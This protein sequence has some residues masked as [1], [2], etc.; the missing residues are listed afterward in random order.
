MSKSKISFSCNFK[1]SE[2][3]SL[4]L[5]VEVRKPNLAL[6]AQALTTQSVDLEPGTYYVTAKL[7][8]GQQLF[9]QVTVFEGKPETVP[10]NPDPEDESPHEWLEKD[11]Y[12]TGQK[13]T[14]PSGAS[15][16]PL[17]GLGTQDVTAKLRAFSGN[18]LLGG[19]QSRDDMGWLVPLPAPSP[20][21][22]K[23]NVF[24]GDV[25]F[26]QL[27]QPKVPALN[28]ALPISMSPPNGCQLVLTRQ[29]NGL[30]SVEAHVEH[31]AADT[32][33]RYFQRGFLE[34]A[35]AMSTSDI[36]QAEQL[37]YQ[38]LSYP[39]AATVGAYALLRFGDLSRLNN[40]TENLNDWFKGLPDGAAIRGEHLARLGK[41]EQALPV[42]LEL[43]SRGL[44][45]FSDGLSYAINR[46]RQ[47]TTVD[48][49]GFETGTRSQAQA[50]LKQLQKFAWHVDYRQ[51]LLIFSGVDPSNPDDEPLGEDIEDFAGLDV[52]QY[53]G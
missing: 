52:A 27:L 5:P 25:R 9:N 50:V 28:I 21:V 23:F 37:L 49:P 24:A 20:G 10:L 14:S 43:P 38:K 18:I 8:A 40:W 22:A 39:I 16:S 44:P 6:V 36:L 3:Q 42:F 48:D 29:S 46:L 33:L 15:G 41:H 2:L 51:P 7:P 35:A 13:T 32:L 34:Q 31:I 1:S 17:E 47:Y 11:T 4:S 53:L 45:I 26:V 30:L 19:A 12:I